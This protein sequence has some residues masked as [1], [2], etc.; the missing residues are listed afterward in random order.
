V[1][2]RLRR[3]GD[4]KN[5]ITALIALCATLNACG[6]STVSARRDLGA[7][8]AERPRVVY[9][10]DFDIDVANVRHEA[11]F[12]P[13]PPLPKPPVIGEWLPA[14]PGEVKDPKV[15]AR[16]LVESMSKSLVKE[17][18]KAG[19]TARRLGPAESIP[20]SGW[21]VRGVFTDVNQGNQLRRAI[22]GFGVGKTDLQ[23]VVG[24]NDLGKGAPEPFYEANAK[25]DSGKAPGA[26]PL[27]VLG[28][29]GAAA[30][31]VLAGGDLNRSVKQAAAKI[32]TDVA[33]RTRI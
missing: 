31:F 18:T 8:P 12:I 32:A 22:I 20:D 19:Y 15:V 23:V 33:E 21:L 9:V 29:A 28:P 5:T 25:A 6:S 24:I 11:G 14:L 7:A 27:I 30:R 2:R 16:E 4:M 1:A 13:P 17:L 3:N 26:G 10:A